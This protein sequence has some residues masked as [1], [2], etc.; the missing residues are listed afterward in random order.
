VIGALVM[1]I[2]SRMKHKNTVIILL[3]MIFVLAVILFPMLIPSDTV[4]T[5]ETM[6]DIIELA[7]RQISRIYPP[8]GLFHEGVIDGNALS[9]LAF[10]ALSF[11]FFAIMVALIHKK[12]VAI[13]TAL[14][15]NAT[16]GN[17]QL[18]ALSQEHIS[19]TL[20]KREIKRYFASAIYVL[21]TLV[22]HLM[23]V[24][25]A[26]ALFFI[27]EESMEV[28]LQMPGV[29]TKPTPF[30]LAALT[31]IVSTTTSAISIE[32]RQWWII[33]SLP[34]ST[35]QLFDG[36]ILVNL[37]ISMP[38][39]LVAEI[40]MQMSL[41]MSMLERIWLIIVPFVYILFA[42]VLGIT[43]NSKMP[44]FDWNS[45]T[46][47]VKQSPSVM[48]AMLVGF[49]VSAVPILLIF[50]LGDSFTNLIMGGAAVLVFGATVALYNMNNKVDL[51]KLV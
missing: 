34:V 41:S 24:V 32:G 23:T 11:G 38:C 51:R 10:L 20:Y 28:M 50:V 46:V 4:I 49:V 22:G 5:I 18:K 42:S 48:I 1:A 9:Y 44:S 39:Y 25:F 19:F 17:Y 47:V 21:N 12:F 15:S 7:M 14:N 33:K 45:E 40:F 27:G 37:T 6:Q 43:L 3:S 26:I 29:I 16:R 31:A 2:G 36:K 35:K 13:C 8:A 30:V